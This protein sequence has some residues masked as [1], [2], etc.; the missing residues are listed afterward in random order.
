MALQVQYRG[1]DV[2]LA[3]GT[4]VGRIRR[5]GDWQIHLC[6]KKTLNSLISLVWLVYPGLCI[7]ISIYILIYI[8]YIHIPLVALL[9]LISHVPCF[10]FKP[11]RLWPG[12]FRDVS[13]CKSAPWNIGWRRPVVPMG[14][15]WDPNG[16]RAATGVGPPEN[17]SEIK[18]TSWLVVITWI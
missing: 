18:L 6:P 2:G 16:P 8:I 7:Y 9:S 10:L 12:I 5:L 14:S 13:T 15:Q 1:F 11:G 17:G 4:W 3:N